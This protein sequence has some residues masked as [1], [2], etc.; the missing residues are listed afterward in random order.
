MDHDEY[1]Q[2]DD[3]ARRA[4]AEA[5]EERRRANWRPSANDPYPDWED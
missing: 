1:R 2:G 3:D 5:K 4:I